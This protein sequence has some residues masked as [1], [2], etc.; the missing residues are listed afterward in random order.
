MYFTA[1]FPYTVLIILFAR[2]VTLPGYMDG[3][4]FYITPQWDKLLKA[5]VSIVE[6][7]EPGIF[8]FRDG[9]VKNKEGNISREGCN[10]IGNSARQHGCRTEGTRKKGKMIYEV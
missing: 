8:F 7:Q 9:G 2:A 4:T 5:R 10:L 3:I 6:L 1:L